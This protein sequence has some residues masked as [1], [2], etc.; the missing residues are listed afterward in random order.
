MFGVMLLMTY[1]CVEWYIPYGSRLTVRIVRTV[2]FH[3]CVKLAELLEVHVRSSGRE[4]S[5]WV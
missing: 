3:V 1:H 2:T 5:A 4:E